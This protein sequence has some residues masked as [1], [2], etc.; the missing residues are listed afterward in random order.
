MKRRVITVGFVIS[1]LAFAPVAQADESGY[2]QQVRSTT[3][4]LFSASDSQLLQLG[5]AACRAFGS[6]PHTPQT[7][8]QAD[9]AVAKFAYYNMG[10]RTGLAGSRFITDA[11]DNNLC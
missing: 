6:G 7:S 1:A 2:L 9:E 3:S 10:F 5:Y 4:G 8:L 11:A